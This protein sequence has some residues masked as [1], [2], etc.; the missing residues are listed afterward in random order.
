MINRLYQSA[1]R[2]VDT[3]VDF[4]CACFQDVRI[5]VDAG[6][7]QRLGQIQLC[8]CL[9]FPYLN[10]LRFFDGIV[11]GQLGIGVQAQILFNFQKDPY[12]IQ[13]GGVIR[14]YNQN[15]LALPGQDA[16]PGIVVPAFI[17]GC[18]H[19]HADIVVLVGF[20][21]AVIHCLIEA[22]GISAVER[23]IPVAFF[24]ENVFKDHFR[25]FGDHF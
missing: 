12:F 24:C 8:V 13:E 10:I 20:I 15:F 23:G 3:A 14:Q 1:D 11:L 9:A 2:L 7:L 18:D 16:E 6:L 17:P 5:N 19:T 25:D 4:L 21:W 22:K